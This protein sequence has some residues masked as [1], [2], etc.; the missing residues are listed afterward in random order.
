M[1]GQRF[2]GVTNDSTISITFVY[3]VPVQ[4]IKNVFAEITR[5]LLL[6]MS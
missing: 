4:E 2:T 1:L 6:K 3:I 5:N